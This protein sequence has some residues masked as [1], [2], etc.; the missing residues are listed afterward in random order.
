[1]R[2]LVTLDLGTALLATAFTRTRTALARSGFATASLLR[3]AA[4]AAFAGLLV[5]AISL[6]ACFTSHCACSPAVGKIVQSRPPRR[7]PYIAQAMRFPIAMLFHIEGTCCTT[8]S[9]MLRPT[10]NAALSI[11]SSLAFYVKCT[12]GLSIVYSARELAFLISALAPC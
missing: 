7:C 9:S 5:T 11:I 3:F 10:N 1:M 2:N 12:C 4:L 8:T 6:T